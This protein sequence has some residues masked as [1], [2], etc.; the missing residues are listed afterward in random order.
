MPGWKGSLPADEVQARVAGARRMLAAPADAFDPTIP[1]SFAGGPP[2]EFVA[3]LAQI[4]TA[5]RP[6]TS[7]RS[8]Q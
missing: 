2:A 8:S 4:A 6:Q 7:A 5:V 3:L 1:G